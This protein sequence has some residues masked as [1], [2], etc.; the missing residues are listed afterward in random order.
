MLTT[1]IVTSNN[2]PICRLTGRAK[3]RLE[4]KPF[5]VFLAMI[6]A[7]VTPSYPPAH[8]E[9]LEVSYSTEVPETEPRFTKR[10]HSE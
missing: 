7:S 4:C 1:L 3:D 5:R 10:E 6:E 9:D 8:V 2:R